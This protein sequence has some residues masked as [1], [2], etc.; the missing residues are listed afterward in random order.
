MKRKFLA[1]L[2]IVSLLVLT[3]ASCDL[4][5]LDDEDDNDTCEHTY[6]DK[7]STNSTEHWHAATCEH[8]ELKND[9][10][11]H[12]D[13]D[14]NGK[15]DVCDYEIGHV[16]TYADIWTA[17]ETHHWKIA[18]CSHTDEKGE[19]GAHT[20]SNS[21]GACDT[22]SSHVHVVDIYGY[23]SVCQ[24]QVADADPSNLQVIV[25]LVLANAGKI[26]GGVAFLSNVNTSIAH[27]SESTRI[28]N[29]IYTLGDG[30][31]YYKIE[32][33]STDIEEGAIS[34]ASD[35][36]ERW[37]ELISDEEVF[38]VYVE[39]EDGVESGYQLNTASLENL[40]GIYYSVSTLTDA[41]GA[42]N[43]LNALYTLSQSDAAFEYFYEYDAEES[44][45]AFSFN[46]LAVNS[47][48]GEGEGNH[49]DYYEL[50]VTFTV[51]AGGALTYLAVECDCYT[52]SLEDEIDNDYTYDQNTN[53]ITMKDTAV[54][55]NYTFIITQTEGERTYVS[56]HPKSSFIP[57][58]FDIFVDEELQNEVDG[59]VEVTVNNVF[60]L[61]VGNYTPA[62]SS[63]SFLADSFNVTI[64]ADAESY[65][66]VTDAISESVIININTAG[67]YT[68]VISAGDIV[69]EITVTATAA[70]GGSD[71]IPD[72]S[73]AVEI[74]DNNTYVDV[75]T[76]TAPADGDYTFY[77]PAG[78]GAWDKI[79]SD[80]NP[81][82]SVPYVDPYY[83]E[84]GGSFT[85]QLL[86]GQ[87]TEFY[88]LSPVKNITLYIEYTVSEY[89]GSG[90]S[91][92]GDNGDDDGPATGVVGG[93][94]LGTN[95]FGS[96]TLIIDT[97][98]S[99][100]TMNGYSYSYTFADGVMTV[101]VNPTLVMP[102][103][104]GVTLGSDG[105]PVS[106]VNNGNT[107]TVSASGDSDEEITIIDGVYT[108]E[109]SS[110]SLTVTVNGDTVT[111]EHSHPMNG[112]TT[113]TVTYSVVAGEIV[114]YDEE[115]YVLSPLAGCA[116]GVD[117]DG[118]LI[119]AA[120]NSNIFEMSSGSGS[121]SEDEDD[122]NIMDGFVGYYEMDGYDVVI[123]ESYEEDD[124]YYLNAFNN[125]Y[126]VFY[127]ISNVADNGDGSYTLVLELLEDNEDSFNFV[128]EV[129]TI[130]PGEDENVLEGPTYVMEPVNYEDITLGDTSIDVTQDDLDNFICYYYDIEI[131]EAGFYVI[132]SDDELSGAFYTTMLDYLGYDSAFLTPGTYVI[133]IN[134]PYEVVPGT[135]TFNISGTPLDEMTENMFFASI[136]GSY[137]HG[138]LYVSV[139][140]DET[141][142]IFNIYDVDCIV[143]VYYTATMTA[144]GDGTYTI[145]LALNTDWSESDGFG[146]AGKTITVSYDNGFVLDF[147]ELQ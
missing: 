29:A 107:Y 130:T 83:D 8:A 32:T 57:T 56:E 109:N 113:L 127:L 14:E 13:A 43:L 47:D 75:A 20:D 87:T 9:V 141:G 72:N 7:W 131:T 106:F 97:E 112:L 6:S 134:L 121:G 52:N 5:K 91:G 122:T 114:L 40:I 81:F 142:C 84:E 73:V 39:T 128:N 38:G 79:E 69:K 44:I 70:G 60:Y 42:E 59:T 4:F 96:C 45:Y 85:V 139:S 61:Y 31:A 105:K 98:V 2:C 120:F 22:C 111:F 33:E 115:G 99:T 63:I 147:S 54:A 1:L 50:E 95:A 53:T 15:C 74:T 76:F 17:N 101:Y 133:V 117:S 48:T 104:L 16:H 80:S 21:D 66:A 103:M 145:T 119:S 110:M 146:F 94:Y 108:G 23:C 34:S 82:G 123:S 89:T 28:Q 136:S 26:N 116:L 132:S 41:Y 78:Y 93:T 124:V 125:I 67:T 24:Q 30:Y 3:F 19:L 92:N 12:T 62:N 58:D 71:D 90:D 143:D 100:V 140:C 126:D 86:E 10:A 138:D 129:F 68:V 35:T 88:V 18:T 135:Y 36:V 137:M 64:D 118:N 144:N 46:Y 27:D 11:S 37:Y 25:P 55:D 51:S 49:V 102:T 77:I 65:F